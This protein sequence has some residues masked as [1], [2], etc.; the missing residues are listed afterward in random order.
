MESTRPIRALLRGLDAL[1]MLNMRGGATVSELAHE[2]R[3][4]RTTVYRILETLCDAGFVVR[5]ANDD[6]YQLTIMVRSLSGGFDDEAW[7]TQVARPFLGELGRD[8]AW[9]VSIATLL[10]TAM[11]VRDTTDH[12]SPLAVERYSAGSRAHLLTSATGRAYLAFCPAQQRETLLDVLA[13]SGQDAD[14]LARPPRTDLRRVL[15]EAKALGYAT[16][17]RAQR[18][19]EEISLSVPV[20]V[21]DRVLACLAVRFTSSAL[22]F[23]TGIERLFPKLR[24]CAA[25]IGAEFARQ[26]AEARR[27]SAPHTAA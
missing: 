8:I 23:T 15:A 7:V 11:V 1:T 21:D 22:P 19:L 25:K 12:D 5:H 14:K 2:I 9:P 4:P 17:S 27:D 16:T 26:N 24:Q 3:L 10:G 18:L 13:K 20:M 6:R